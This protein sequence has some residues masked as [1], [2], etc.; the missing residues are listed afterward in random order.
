MADLVLII[1]FDGLRPDQV[2]AE[3]CPNLYGLARRGVEF[4]NHH[5]T[6]P[7]LTRVNVASLFTGCHPGRHGITTNYMY[8]PDVD[9]T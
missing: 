3:N 6:F 9:P 4:I 7:T 2:T 8:L 5:A 1:V